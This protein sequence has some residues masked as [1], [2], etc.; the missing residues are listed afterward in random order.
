MR[1]LAIP[2]Y[3]IVGEEEMPKFNFYNLL[4]IVTGLTFA[5]LQF[6]MRGDASYSRTRDYIQIPKIQVYQNTDGYDLRCFMGKR[7]ESG[8]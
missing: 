4:L 7:K 8:E 1:G 3:S 5:M 6:S 2:D